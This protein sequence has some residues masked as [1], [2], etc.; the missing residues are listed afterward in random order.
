MWRLG[1]ARLRFSVRLAWQELQ[2][3][4]ISNECLFGSLLDDLFLERIPGHS[5]QEQRLQTELIPKRTVLEIHLVF[6]GNAQTPLG[7]FNAPLIE[8]RQD[9]FS[10]R[11][12]GSFQLLL[13]I[14]EQPTQA[15][16]DCCADIHFLDGL[17]AG[18]LEL[19]ETLL[20]LRRQRLDWR[21]FRPIA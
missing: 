12:R 8:I 18:G 15:N 21:L 19:R 10:K 17:I 4:E 14:V 2:S 6:L 7:A 9:P 20:Y 1:F 16:P 11:D 3:F 13:G 5:I